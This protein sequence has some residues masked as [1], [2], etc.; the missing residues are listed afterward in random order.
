MWLYSANV[1]WFWIKSLPAGV[2]VKHYRG[3]VRTAISFPIHPGIQSLPHSRAVC[4]C[5]CV[6]S[7]A[8]Q[9][10][11]M[12]RT[13]MM[14]VLGDSPDTRKSNGYQ[15]SNS[16]RIL[17]SV[18]SGIAQPAGYGLQGKMHAHDC[19]HE[20]HCLC[21]ISKQ[22]IPKVTINRLCTCKV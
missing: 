10:L 15:N 17:D 16:E 21:H 11:L 19:G 6:D 9:R 4:V 1:R 5:V 7:S 8:R 14:R 2:A 13:T 18:G 12:R 20:L 3:C 22:G